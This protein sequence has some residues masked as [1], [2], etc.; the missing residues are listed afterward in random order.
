MVRLPIL[1]STTS[2]KMPRD[3]LC[4]ILLTSAREKES[5]LH[6]V[7]AEAKTIVLRMIE[8]TH[9]TSSRMSIPLAPVTRIAKASAFVM[10]TVMFANSQIIVEI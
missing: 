3:L 2:H 1:A 10:T 7:T 6:M 5:A 8:I 4:A 9:A